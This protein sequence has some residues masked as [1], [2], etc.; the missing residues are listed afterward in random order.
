MVPNQTTAGLDTNTLR[1]LLL[2]RTARLSEGLYN[3]QA[4]VGKWHLQMRLELEFGQEHGPA[5][6]AMLTRC[7]D[8][9][10]RLCSTHCSIVITTI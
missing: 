9:M 5:L 2:A 4:Q 6:R 8:W 10:G 7:T 1:L 3:R